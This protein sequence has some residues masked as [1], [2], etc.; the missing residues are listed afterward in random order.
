MYIN[1]ACPSLQ[2]CAPT[3]N[4]LMINCTNF[5]DSEKNILMKVTSDKHAPDAKTTLKSEL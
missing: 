5:S 4:A 1:L 2:A 3:T